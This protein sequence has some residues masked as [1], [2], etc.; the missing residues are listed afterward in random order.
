MGRSASIIAT[1]T[2]FV[3]FCLVLAHA[4][5][6]V[7]QSTNS[8]DPEAELRTGTVLTRSGKLEE[9]IPHLLAARG[10][11][12]EEYAASFNLA[13]CYFGTRRYPQ[14][15]S[16]LEELRTQGQNT[17]VVSNLLAQTYAAASQ[18][19][20]A[21]AAFQQAA[22]LKPTDEKM[23]AFM[24]DACTDS[25]QYD[26]G[27]HVVDLGLKNLP[28]SARLHYE[29]A[30][31][32]A[33]L[34][35]FEVAKPEFERAVTLAPDSDIAGLA[36]TQ[37]LLFEDNIQE[38]IRTAREAISK[39]HHDYVLEDLLAEVLIH[40]GATPGQP[41]FDE[42]RSLLESATTQKPDYSTAQIALGKLYLMENRPADAVVHLEIG[43]SLQPR[44]PAVYTSLANA[45]RR[46][47]EEQKARQMLAELK[48]LL[49]N[50][51]HPDANLQK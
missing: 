1:R 49:E 45:Y 28:S 44:N 15:I 33:Q 9:A 40:T 17:A 47:G 29:R 37:E 22:A 2:A 50:D 6:S 19:E 12:K 7:A 18:P 35:R 23:Y 39:G 46:L 41:E 42:T 10:H 43:R 3:L 48:T 25:R 51:N 16:L 36:R 8:T 27:L 14:S 32:L 11:V 5:P 21:F 34:D 38:A 20:K 30:M 13:L 26:L 31:F 24:A 4:Q